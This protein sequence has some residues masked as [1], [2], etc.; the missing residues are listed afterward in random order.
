METG[1]P[2]LD[3]DL[4]LPQL[5]DNLDIP[6]HYLSQVIN[7]RYGLNFHDFVNRYRVEEFKEKVGSAEFVNFTLLGIAFECG[8]NSKSA[9]NRVFRQ[10]TGVTPSQYKKTV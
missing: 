6:V 8:F 10:F 4:S 2:Y 7:G 1:K 3:P 5:S 9:F